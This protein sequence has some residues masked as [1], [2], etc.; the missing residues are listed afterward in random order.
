LIRFLKGSGYRV[1]YKAHPDR[2]KEIGDLFVDFVDEIVSEPFEASWKKSDAF[3]FTHTGSTT[4]GYSLSLGNRVVLINLEN[5]PITIDDKHM[6]NI[7]R[8]VPAKMDIDNRIQFDKK[9]LLDSLA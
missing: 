5:C 8:V 4:F 7:F 6:E 1:I 2:L 9:N 3:I